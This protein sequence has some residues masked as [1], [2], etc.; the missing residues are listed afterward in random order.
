MRAC[1][2]AFINF[3]PRAIWKYKYICI[4]SLIPV[5]DCMEIRICHK[6]SDALIKI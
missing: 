1:L 5:K 6:K 2:I 4:Y 3:F